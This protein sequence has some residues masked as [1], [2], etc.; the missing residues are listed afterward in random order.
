M[1]KNK[2]IK[3]SVNTESAVYQA[4]YIQEILCI[5]RSATY[6]YL[7]EV[8]KSKSPFRVIKIGSTFRVPK[9]EFDEWLY[10]KDDADA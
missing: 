5:S 9:K 4:Q 2:E 10:G 3:D 8:Y 6:N 7:N 1:D